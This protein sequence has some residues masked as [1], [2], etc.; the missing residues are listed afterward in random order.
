MPSDYHDPNGEV[1]MRRCGISPGLKPAPRVIA[2]ALGIAACGS[3]PTA[4]T[5]RELVGAWGSAQAELIAI[6]AGAEFR[7]PCTRFIIDDPIM[8][9]QANAF[10]VQA[11]VDGPGFTAGELPVVRLTG[12]VVGH[13]TTIDVP[14]GAQTPA[15][16][17]VLDAGVRPDPAEEPACPA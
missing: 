10:A 13:Q 7:I 8:L 11:R 3:N 5:G 6:Y 14:A 9:D 12:A 16:R 2:A 1:Y 15:T 17:Y 4:P